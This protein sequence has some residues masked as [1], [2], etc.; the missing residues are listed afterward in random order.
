MDQGACTIEHGRQKLLMVVE[1]AEGRKVAKASQITARRADMQTVLSD[2][3]ILA[4]QVSY[5]DQAQLENRCTPM[6]S[7]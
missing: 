2:V 3:C 7:P 6:R 1:I 4:D 5:L